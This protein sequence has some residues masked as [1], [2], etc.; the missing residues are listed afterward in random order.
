MIESFSLIFV[1]IFANAYNSNLV[2]EMDRDEEIIGLLMFSIFC[3]PLHK[4][5]IAN[6]IHLLIFRIVSNATL[7]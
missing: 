6:I 4:F 3:R 1:I 5:W 2:V 7:R